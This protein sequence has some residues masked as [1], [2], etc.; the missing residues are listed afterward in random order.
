MQDMRESGLLEREFLPVCLEAV[1]V[2]EERFQVL[3]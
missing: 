2:D 3:V 1:Q